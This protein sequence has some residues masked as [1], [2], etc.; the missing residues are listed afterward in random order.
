MIEMA[1]VGMS[2]QSHGHEHVAMPL[3]S[4]RLLIQQLTKPKGLLEDRIGAPVE[5][6]AVPYGF[7][8]S[9][10]IEA[11]MQVGYKGVCVP[12]NRPARLGTPIIRRI[13][14]HED[15]SQQEFE[16]LLALRSGVYLKRA[17]RNTV[18]YLPKQVLLRVRPE[19]LGVQVIEEGT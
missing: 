2:I 6:L 12:G 16:D 4:T 19:L 15:T 11:A 1:R 13:A 8:D 18:A 9:R 17:I 14:I 10:L 5:F 7:V 3:L